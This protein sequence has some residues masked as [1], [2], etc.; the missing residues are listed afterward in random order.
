MLCSSCSALGPA[1]P[2][3]GFGLC[4]AFVVVLLCFCLLALF[5]KGQ[6][7]LFCDFKIFFSSLLCNQLPRSSK[8]SLLK[9]CCLQCLLPPPVCFGGALHLPS[10]LFEQD[11]GCLTCSG[12]PALR[13]AVCL[14]P[15]C[16]QGGCLDFRRLICP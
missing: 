9:L 10:S 1:P 13:P 4:C 8:C 2:S 5:S 16:F 7:T 14:Y 11:L 3:S 15:G 6:L 12:L